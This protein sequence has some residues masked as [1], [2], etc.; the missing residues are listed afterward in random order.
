[1]R[2]APWWR[3]ASAWRTKTIH[4]SLERIQCSTRDE[5]QLVP[6]F[7][8]LVPPPT[9]LPPVSAAFPQARALRFPRALHTSSLNIRST[10]T[11]QTPD[12]PH[13]PC[14]QVT[15]TP[16][17]H[18]AY[19]PHSS[20]PPHGASRDEPEKRWQTRS[21]SPGA[22]SIPDRQA[23]QLLPFPCHPGIPLLRRLPQRAPL[24]GARHSLSLPGDIAST[25]P[26]ASLPPAVPLTH[27]LG[28]NAQPRP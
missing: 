9:P 19:I 17:A 13:E 10:Q 20:T 6:S 11:V 4:G 5:T 1:M 18:Q 14:P 26:R 3:L 28:K 7:R 15:G 25:V 8:L 23:Q 16:R 22:A 21:L 27:V 12:L 2:L 24:P